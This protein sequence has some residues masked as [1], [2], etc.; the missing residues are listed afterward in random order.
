MTASEPVDQSALTPDD[1]RSDNPPA[2]GPVPPIDQQRRGALRTITLNR[3]QA[4]NALDRDT[5]ARIAAAIPPIARDADTYAVVLRS[6]RPGVFCAGGDLREL[7]GLAGR[8]PAAAHAALAGEYRLVW[9][10]ECFSKPTIS[11]IDGAV[12]GGGAG[13]TLVNTHRVA[14][15][16]YAFAMPEVHIGFF[17]DDAVAHAL[18]RLPGAMGEYLALTG[19]RIDRADA[20]ALGLASHCIDE[21][22]FDAIETALADAQPVDALLE[23]L[24]REPGPGLL[25]AM[26]GPIDDCFSQP[27]VAAIA[28]RIA[29]LAD[30]TGAVAVWARETRDALA[31]AAPFALAVALRHVRDARARDLRLTLMVDYRLGCR[32][33]ARNDFR[34]GVRA[35]VIDKDRKAIWRPAGNDEVSP[36]MVDEVF[37]PDPRHDINLPTRQEMQAA[38]V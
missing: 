24:H 15:R 14:G 30:G 22:H 16:G 8:D 9:L 12:I 35:V 5:S 2:P 3:P 18:A 17:P 27:S 23:R 32:L 31:A 19:R 1:H 28:A 29:S 10:L 20:F 26:Q 25:T 4:R 38:R 37:K 34:E 36:N 13:I 11:L 6:S 21:E 33:I 7:V